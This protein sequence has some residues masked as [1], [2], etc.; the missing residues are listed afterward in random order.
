MICR[1]IHY[2]LVSLIFTID[3]CAGREKD[4]MDVDRFVERRLNCD[5]FRGELPDP[6]EKKRLEEV[7]D[8]SNEFCEGTDAQLKALKERYANNPD[9]MARLNQ[10]ENQIESHKRL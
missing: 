2:A 10:F 5:H 4:M 6:S 8:A 7:I 9:V 1:N 3:A